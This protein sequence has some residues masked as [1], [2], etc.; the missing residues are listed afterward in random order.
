MNKPNRSVPSPLC[1][2]LLHLT[3]YDPSPRLL[4][5]IVILVIASTVAA[6]AFA[7][8]TQYNFNTCR[9]LFH[10]NV[11]AMNNKGIC[12]GGSGPANAGPVLPGGATVGSA[13][14]QLKTGMN[15]SVYQQTPQRTITLPTFQPKR[16]IVYPNNYQRQ[17]Q[18]PVGYFYVPGQNGGAVQ[19]SNQSGVGY[20]YNSSNGA[21][22]YNSV[23]SGSNGR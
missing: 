4:P 3:R 19:N 12:T 8:S 11:D 22:T 20:Q 9:Y 17:P 10:G 6:P 23:S 5:L 15:V 18:R 21:A 1:P 14:E 2:R 13:A 7:K 16:Q